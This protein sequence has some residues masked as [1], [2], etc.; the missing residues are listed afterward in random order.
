MH[1]FFADA[2]ERYGKTEAENLLKK[3]ER[4]SDVYDRAARL[5]KAAE[6]AQKR[7]ADEYDAVHAAFCFTAPTDEEILRH[8]ATAM[9]NKNTG[10]GRPPFDG[11]ST[12]EIAAFH[13]SM[14]F[15]ANDEARASDAEW[16]MIVD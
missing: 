16:S 14:M 12:D 10:A 5:V 15:G 11:L 13:A 9:V 2:V 7:A 6:L 8:C 1:D 3:L 4:A